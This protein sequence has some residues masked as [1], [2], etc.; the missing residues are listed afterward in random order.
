LIVTTAL[1]SFG[2]D[3][4]K[5]IAEFISEGAQ[6]TPAT[7]QTFKLIDAFNHQQLIVTYVNTNSKIS[8]IFREECRTFCEGKWE[9]NQQIT[10]I[11][12]DD[13]NATIS[14]RLVGIGQTGLMGLVG[15]IG[16]I[17]TSALI[18]LALSVTTI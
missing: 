10:Q 13:S 12:D 7:L 5:L 17:N 9:Q 15:Q 8:L 16:S 11:F 1:N 14:Q 2:A 3:S 6:F 4:F 18:T